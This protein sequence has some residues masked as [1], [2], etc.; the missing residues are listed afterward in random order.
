MKRIAVIGATGTIGQAVAS[1]LEARGDDVIRLSRKS[2]PAIDIEDPASIRAG[3]H[4]LGTV[5][6]LVCLA[7]RASFGPITEQS[8]EAV[9]LGL[10]SKLRGQVNLVR[11]GPP[12]LTPGGVLVL[13]SGML[14]HTPGPGTSAVALVNGAIESFVRAAALDLP[15]HRVEVVCPPLVKETAIAMNRPQ[16]PAP[17]AAEVAAHYLQAIDGPTT[18]TTHF[19][20]GFG[21]KGAA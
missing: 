8:D 7:G 15:N 5:D 14:A 10:H 3:L 13:T 2:T 19:V 12:H 18:G 20:T 1:A 16:I 9:D 4:A 6:A 11:F 17:T 21:P